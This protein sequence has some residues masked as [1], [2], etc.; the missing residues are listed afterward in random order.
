VALT[1]G[2]RRVN[3][4]ANVGLAPSSKGHS[5]SNSA[6]LKIVFI[7]YLSAA[8][9]IGGL[10]LPGSQAA[11][12]QNHSSQTRDL[13]EPKDHKNGPIWTSWKYLDTAISSAPA[14]VSRGNGTIDLFVRGNDNTLWQRSWNGSSWT[15]WK[16][17]QGVLSSSPAV[18]STGP[19]NLEV[20]VKGND[21]TLWQRS[22]EWY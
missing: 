21:N 18:I 5:L 3:D 13:L 19:N 22:C 6:I 16:D 12:E 15:S 1:N 7:F 9:T 11:P 8:F 14:A 4:L 2:P 10:A 17:L 20:F